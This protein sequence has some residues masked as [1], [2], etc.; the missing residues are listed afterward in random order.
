MVT[1]EIGTVA[2]R[3]ANMEEIV[4]LMVFLENIRSGQERKK[5]PEASE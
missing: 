1:P 4:E 2:E 5:M 3:A